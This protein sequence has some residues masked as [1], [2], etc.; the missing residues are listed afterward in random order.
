MGQRLRPAAALAAGAPAAAAVGLCWH[1]D[2]APEQR[3]TTFCSEVP[4]DSAVSCVEAKFNGL[5]KKGLVKPGDW[6]VVTLYPPMGLGNIWDTIQYFRNI[7][8]SPVDVKVWNARE[9]EAREGLS[10]VEFFNK[11]GFVLI[12]RKTAMTAQDW[13]VSAPKTLDMSHFTGYGMPKTETP[14]SR[15]Y[16]KEVEQIVRELLPEA[17]ELELDPF[18]ARRGPGTKNPTYSFAVHNDYGFVAD[19]WPAASAGFQARFARPEVRGVMALNFWRPVLPMRGPV[20]R[21]PL[22]VC[23]PR[24]VEFDDIVPVSIKW[25]ELPHHRMLNLRPSEGQR[26]YY[27]PE[28]TVDEVLVFKSFQYFKAQAGPE[29]NTCFHTAFEVP[30]SPREAEPRQSAEYRVR[31]WF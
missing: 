19:D 15:I 24:S 16:A 14:L 1:L 7:I 10:K 6:Q 18:C 5:H 12:E 3:R 31:V 9:A 4:S 23:D 28:M 29:F 30:G 26:W 11:H 17:Q 2:A 13:N 25:D 27:Y 22:A 20:L 21:H 8:R